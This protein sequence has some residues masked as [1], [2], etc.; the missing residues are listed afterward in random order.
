MFEKLTGSRGEMMNAIKQ[1]I[2]CYFKDGNF[3]EGR[4]V[5]LA[6]MQSLSEAEQI[7]CDGDAY[8]YQRELQTAIRRYEEAILKYPDHAIARYQYLVGTQEERQQNYV[9][10]FKRYQA[11]IGIEPDFVDS[12]VELGG[13]LTKVEDFSGAAQCFRDAVR[14]DPLD[15]ANHHNLKEVLGRLAKIEPGRHE[16]ELAQATAAYEMAVQQG[17]A[18]ALIAHQW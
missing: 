9:D 18:K 8:F 11:A 5:L 1:A 12:Y 16:E 14:L 17:T 10:A 2:T 7:E 6:N 4:A 15:I 3:D 13:L